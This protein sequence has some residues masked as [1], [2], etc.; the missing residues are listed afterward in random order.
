MNLNHDS[1]L[2]LNLLSGHGDGSH[3]A[4]ICHDDPIT[5]MMSAS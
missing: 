3:L 5:N 1:V 4:V 2:D